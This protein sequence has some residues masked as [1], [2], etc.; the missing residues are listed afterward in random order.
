MCA[1]FEYNM[2][3]KFPMNCGK[4][5]YKCTPKPKGFENDKELN[6]QCLW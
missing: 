5:L 6:Q 3:S 1:G 4:I 2:Q